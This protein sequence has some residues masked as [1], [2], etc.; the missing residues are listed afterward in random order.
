MTR[1]LKTSL[2]TTGNFFFLIIVY[3]TSTSHNIKKVTPVLHIPLY[4]L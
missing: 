2:N 3:A 1:T 4:N